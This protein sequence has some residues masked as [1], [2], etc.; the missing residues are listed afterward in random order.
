[1][2]LPE[3]GVGIVYIPGLESLLEQERVDLIEV[4][5]QTLWRRRSDGQYAFP[6][7]SLEYLA[8]LPQPKVIH[9]VG[10]AVAGSRAPPEEFVAALKRSVDALSAPWASD[11]LSFTQAA[12]DGRDVFT[13]FMLPPLLTPA[14]VAVAAARIRDLRARLGIPLAVETGVNYLAARRG[15]MTD[16]EFVSAV[17]EETGCGILLDLHNVWANERNG[18]QSLDS[19]LRSIPLEQVW[20]LH[21]A[22]GFEFGGYWLDSHSGAI[23]PELMARAHQ[24]VHR[25]PNLKAIVYEVFSSYLP[26]FGVDG[27]KRELGRIRSL[28]KR[29]AKPV[30]VHQRLP[31]LPSSI[32]APPIVQQIDRASVSELK[33]YQWEQALAA[34]VVTRRGGQGWVQE[35]A[36]DSAVPLIRTIIWKFRA[37]AISRAQDTLFQLLLATLGAP[38]LDQLLDGYFES[39][40]PEPF[41]SD[42]AHGFVRHILAKRVEVPYLFDVIRYEDARGRAQETDAL[43]YVRFGYDPRPLLVALSRG[44]LPDATTPGNYELEVYPM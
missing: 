1:M 24:L 44:T 39:C 27:V 40:P 2:S 42:E 22:G 18:R 20:E 12:A 9:S 11:H 25:L 33:P 16:G 14:G 36:K 13:S 41:A 17:V 34:A 37:G 19:F 21:L 30:G 15:E 38:T 29:R 10:H 4:E 7:R 26:R 3:L 43:Q 6:C 5:P 32:A 31:R 35:L 8:S 23:P 28:W